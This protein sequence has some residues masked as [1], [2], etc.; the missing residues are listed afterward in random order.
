MEEKAWT[1]KTI[2]C[3]MKVHSVPGPGFLES[4]Y[5]K[6]QAQRFYPVNPVHPVKR[7]F[8]VAVHRAG[9]LREIHP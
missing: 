6:A 7:F 4:V 8:S 3:A 9:P 2:G 1:E 5:A